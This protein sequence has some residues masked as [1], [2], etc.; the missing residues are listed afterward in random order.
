MIITDGLIL[1]MM[2][3]VFGSIFTIQI[4]EIIYHEYYWKRG[5]A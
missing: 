1:K 4:L 3:L 2:F 5:G